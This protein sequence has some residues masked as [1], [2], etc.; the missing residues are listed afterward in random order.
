MEERYIKYDDLIEK[1]K[2]YNKS[3]TL[4]SNDNFSIETLRID[5][6][7]EDLY[8]YNFKKEENPMT[9]EPNYLKKTE[10]EEKLN[11]NRN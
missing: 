10:A 6:N 1:V 5:P 8:K 3:T 11:D 2:S 4:I 7:L 9:F